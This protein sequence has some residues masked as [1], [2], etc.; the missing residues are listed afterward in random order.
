MLTTAELSNNNKGMVQVVGENSNN[1][2]ESVVGE[3]SNNNK[4]FPQP[5]RCLKLRGEVELN[6]RE[7]FLR[8][9]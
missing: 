8:H 4:E 3:I 6:I 5:T 9:F 2:K 1:N 7:S